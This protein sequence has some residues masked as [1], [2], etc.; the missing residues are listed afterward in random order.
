MYRSV[1]FVYLLFKVVSVQSLS[2]DGATEFGDGL[3]LFKS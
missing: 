2:C 1:G 3:F